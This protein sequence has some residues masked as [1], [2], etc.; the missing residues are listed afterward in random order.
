MTEK[1][2]DLII[3]MPTGGNRGALDRLEQLGYPIRRITIE[4]IADIY[5]AIREIAEACAI[6][7]RGEQ[8]AGS[9]R[10]QIATIRESLRQ[11]PRVKALFVVDRNP[12]IVAGKGSYID[13]LISIAGGDNVAGDSATPYPQMSFERVLARAPEVI[14]DTGFMSEPGPDSMEA[15]RRFW[16]RYASLPAVSRNR[17][18]FTKDS[19]LFVPGPRII[20][21]LKT[22]CKHLHPQANLCRGEQ[23]TG[24]AR[25]E[26]G[27]NAGNFIAVLYQETQCPLA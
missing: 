20:E 7:E 23:H 6:P 1:S 11:A 2:T 4:G 15:A 8:L 10:Q 18:I 3:G 19:S 5:T 13:E 9:L 17:L 21:G 14:I 16:S 24:E 25:A 26:G 12:L 22:L 27:T